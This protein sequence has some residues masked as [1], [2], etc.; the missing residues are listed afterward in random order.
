[1]AMGREYEALDFTTAIDDPDSPFSAS[2]GGIGE[3]ATVLASDVDEGG[4]IN[5]GDPYVMLE[6]EYV[7]DGETANTRVFFDADEF[8]D[9]AGF[10]L[11][12]HDG[13]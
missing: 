2:A 5:G 6:F 4:E 13:R 1:M 12:E 3:D 8:A 9:M 11:E 7:D 10:I